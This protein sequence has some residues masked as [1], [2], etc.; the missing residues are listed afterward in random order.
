MYENMCTIPKTYLM[1]TECLS[2]LDSLRGGCIMNQK[3]IPNTNIDRIEVFMI[4]NVNY[5]A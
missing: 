4:R 5:H 3:H 1:F 2:S